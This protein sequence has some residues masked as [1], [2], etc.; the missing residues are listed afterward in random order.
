MIDF[1]LNLSDDKEHR[2]WYEGN[3][4]L[5]LDRFDR[6]LPDAGLV[7]ENGVAVKSAMRTAL[8]AKYAMDAA[9]RAK[10]DADPDAP[11][12]YEYT[13]RMNEFARTCFRTINETAGTKDAARV[14]A[15][16][17]GPVLAANQEAQWHH[18]W[19][20]LLYRL[21]SNVPRTL[22]SHGI[23]NSSA[24][25]LVEIGKHYRDEVEAIEKRVEAANLEPRVGWDLVVYE[26][27]WRENPEGSPLGGLET[28]LWCQ[29]FDRAWPEVMR[30]LPPAYIDA[31]IQWG[32]AEYG[33]G[34]VVTIPDDI[35]AAWHQAW[36]N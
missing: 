11:D 26:D 25:K 21:A 23:P 3:E 5:S 20:I 22:M 7:L 36:A 9:N 12:T 34:S 33:P 17:K 14:A 8:M 31:L 1:P 2:A 24:H 4:W 6:F 18:G 30:C 27:Y 13:D 28:F 15:W 32:I 16:L 35:R 10:W 29:L 19:R